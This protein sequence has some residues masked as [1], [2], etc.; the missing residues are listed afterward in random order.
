MELLL[1]VPSKQT[2]CAWYQSQKR[3]FNG[4]HEQNSSGTHE[5][6]VCQVHLFEETRLMRFKIGNVYL[7]VDAGGGTAVGALFASGHIKLS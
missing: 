5:W 2:R 6:K 3:H 1:K 4:G 7:V